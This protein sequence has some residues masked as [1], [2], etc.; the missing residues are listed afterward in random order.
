MPLSTQHRGD[1]PRYTDVRCTRSPKRDP[2]GG[3]GARD[4][5]GTAMTVDGDPAYRVAVVGDGSAHPH[6]EAAQPLAMALA[7]DADAIEWLGG[8]R[9]M[10]VRAAPPTRWRPGC[11]S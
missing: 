10:A 1:F 5:R 11:G 3:F 8:I 4:R 6:P 7:A 2:H 9:V